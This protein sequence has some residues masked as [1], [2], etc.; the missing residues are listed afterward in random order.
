M[1]PEDFFKLYAPLAENAQIKYGVPASITL[2]QAA[3]ESAWGESTLTKSGKNFF[4]IK[5]DASW[6]GAK[7]TMG[8]IEN[9]G[10]VN[11]TQKANFRIYANAQDGF[12]DHA[13]FLVDNKRYASLF[14][15]P[16]TDYQN[17]AIGLSKAGYATD[18]DYSGKLIRLINKWQLME[19]DQ[20]AIKKKRLEL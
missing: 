14:K 16:V 4:G 7:T 10:G 3:L 19:Y 8:T 2:A 12:N 18:P 13:K 1:A 20:A 9:I 5:A 11:Q 17:W 15:L 6:T